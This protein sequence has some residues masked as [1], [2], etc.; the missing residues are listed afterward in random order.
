MPSLL[1]SREA[2]LG[3]LSHA[4]L[5]RSFSCRSHQNHQ[6]SYAQSSHRRRKSRGQGFIATNTEDPETLYYRLFWSKWEKVKPTNPIHHWSLGHVTLSNTFF[7]AWN[8]NNINLLGIYL[9]GSMVIIEQIIYS[10]P[11]SRSIRKLTSCSFPLSYLLN[12]FH[13]I[14]WPFNIL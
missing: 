8:L 4:P 13:I 7:W 1:C 6:G 11:T 3:I 14:T 9:N 12:I 5:S 10:F 2:Y